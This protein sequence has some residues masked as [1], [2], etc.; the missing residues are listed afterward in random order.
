ML[1][2]KVIVIIISIFINMFYIFNS[3]IV[4]S[5]TIIDNSKRILIIASYDT[6]N[7]WEFSVINAFKEK[8]SKGNDIRIEYLDS[9]SNGSDMY[10]DSFLHLLNLKYKN[11]SIDCIVAIDDEAFN[12]V[13]K[14]LFNEDMFFC[15]KPVVFVGV[16]KYNSLSMEECK[17]MTGL[18]E[19]QD[20]SSMIDIILSQRETNDIYVL[21]DNSIYSKT[22]K[23]NIEKINVASTIPFNA[24][25]IE[26]TYLNDILNEISII[27]NDKAALYLC[28]TFM[29]NGDKRLY[30]Q[31]TINAIKECSNLPLYAKLEHYVKAGAIGGI[32]NDGNKLGKTAATLTEEFLNN[33]ENISVIPLYN[34]YN[35]SV[36]N[37]KVMR[38]YNINPLKL[39]KNTIYINKGPLDLLLPNYLIIIIWAIIIIIIILILFLI[40]LYYNHRKMDRKNRILLAE[41]EER[42]KVNTDFIITLSHELRTPLNIIISSGGMLIERVVQEKYNKDIFN[43]KLQFIMKNSYRLS[44][45]INNIIDSSKSEIGYMDINCKN[46]NIVALVEEVLQLSIDVARKH[47]IE[48]I[49]DTEEEE[50]I[51]AVDE[52]KICKVILIILSNAIKF[53][54]EKGK[55][56]VYMKIK[57]KDVIIKFTD[58]GIG[59]SEEMIDRVFDKFKR[60]QSV[61][62]L[63]IDQEGSGLGL[64]IAKRFIDLHNGHIEVDSEKEKGTTFSIKIPLLKLEDNLSNDI[65]SDD[66]L[67]RIVK[68]ELSDL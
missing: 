7:Q 66:E 14:N 33:Y 6:E 61:S 56:Y 39:P 30:S 48:I 53:S 63:N 29:D 27:D 37:Y 3:S 20:N 35:T 10:N 65:L 4:F 8:L 60:V 47:N 40:Y 54:K 49:F 52:E 5:E 17:Y 31:E 15:K 12:I 50:I 46:I 67:K 42:N 19:Y 1:N 55:I 44:R 16:N 32:I 34:T 24:H 25:F 64:Y 11:D 18:M 28:G 51:T 43:E 68:L 38:E 26:S 36:F 9:K 21:L 58:D 45:Y 62:D 41:A 22:I 59:I 57:D 2:K 23:E 13:R